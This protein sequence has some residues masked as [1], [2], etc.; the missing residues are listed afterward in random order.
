VHNTPMKMWGS[1][2]KPSLENLQ[3]SLGVLSGIL[4]PLW[5]ISP[6]LRRIAGI[7]E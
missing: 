5:K 4:L 7:D 2:D 6:P 1:M 3:C